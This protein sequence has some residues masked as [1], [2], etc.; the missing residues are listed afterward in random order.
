MRCH[1]WEMWHGRGS[2]Q[3]AYLSEEGDWLLTHGVCVPD[4]GLDDLSERLLHSL[5]TE[6]INNVK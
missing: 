2:V 6:E 4:V 1:V 3:T 5:Q